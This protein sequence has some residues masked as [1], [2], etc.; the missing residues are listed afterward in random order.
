MIMEIISLVIGLFICYL[1]G[2]VWFYVVTKGENYSF[3][4]ILLLCVIPYIIPDLLKLVLAFIIARRLKK[5]L[6]KEVSD[7]E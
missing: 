7:Y 3:F 6:F 1:I 2:T 5:V 4:K